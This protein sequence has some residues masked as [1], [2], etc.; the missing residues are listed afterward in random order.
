MEWPSAHSVYADPGCTKMRKE[1][2]DA[3]IILIRDSGR[4][5]YADGADVI[6]WNEVPPYTDWASDRGDNSWCAFC[7]VWGLLVS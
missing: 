5:E 3:T 7:S 6:A 1:R 2:G 4:S